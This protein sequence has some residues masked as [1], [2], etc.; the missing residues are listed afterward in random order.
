MEKLLIR[1]DISNHFAHVLSTNL[2]PMIE[3][4]VKE[5]VTKTFIPVYTQ[6][7]STM[8][9]EI[10]RELRNEIHS[11]KTEL[12]AWQNEAFRSHEVIVLHVRQKFYLTMAFIQTSIR[13]LEHTV[14]T[15]SDQVKFLSMNPPAPHHHLQ[16]TQP[17]Q[18]SPGANVPQLQGS[19]NQSHVRQQN[20]PPVPPA[21]ASYNHPSHANFQQPTQPMHAPWYGASI[22]APQA[23]HPA[24][25]PQPPP[26][27]QTQ[28]ERTPPIKPEQWDEIYLG[29]LHTQ[30]ASKLRDL[31]S[32]TNPEVIMPLNGVSLVSQAVILTLVHRVCDLPSYMCLS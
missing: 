12:T 30:D 25:I 13:E 20:L 16:Q 28:A 29:V 14:R 8:H 4:H 2:T 21:P 15:L 6:Q 31:L 23:S 7:S 11:V 22:A 32:H 24:T 5:A 27:T 3:R 10:L 26:P 17:S 9:Q 1:P 19:I 18:S